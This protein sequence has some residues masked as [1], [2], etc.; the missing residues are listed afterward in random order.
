MSEAVVYRHKWTQ[1]LVELRR[2]CHK[3]P[4]APARFQFRHFGELPNEWGQFVISVKRI[5]GFASVE[6]KARR[7]GEPGLGLKFFGMRTRCGVLQSH[8]KTI[9]LAPESFL[10]D[11]AGVLVIAVSD[12][13]T[14][15]ET[16]RLTLRTGVAR[17]YSQSDR[18]PPNYSYKKIFSSFAV[19]LQE[20]YEKQ[21][22]IRFPVTK[23]N[24]QLGDTLEF[25]YEMFFAL[26]ND[27]TAVYPCSMRSSI[28]AL[29]LG[30]PP[31]ES[32][33][34]SSA[35][36]RSSTPPSD[37]APSAPPASSVSPASGSY[38][39]SA[40]ARPSKSLAP[41]PEPPARHRPVGFT[42]S[43]YNAQDVLD[44]L[45]ETG[46]EWLEAH[47]DFAA[48]P[49]AIKHAL[50]QR[51]GMYTATLFYHPRI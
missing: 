31:R 18:P 12:P 6:R 42:K 25:E 43:G 49:Y 50:T 47:P 8:A 27:P 36:P 20:L 26:K 22:F 2:R 30:S 7:H 5:D 9:D 1:S 33:S 15:T 32:S 16:S 48:R 34:P 41:A 39:R 37:P 40:P 28:E 11:D 3:S 51:D 17:S 14:A 35:S 21:P 38:S 19:T 44:A 24:K 29:N 46:A 45:L 4:G 10:G 13:T 23:K